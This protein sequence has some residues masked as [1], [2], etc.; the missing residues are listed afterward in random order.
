M[1]NDSVDRTWEG[2][3]NELIGRIVPEYPNAMVF[4]WKTLA[5]AHPEWLW[6]D[7]IHPRPAGADAIA[8]MLLDEAVRAVA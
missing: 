6:G 2:H 7:G 5:A 4:D 3:N 8:A 1:L